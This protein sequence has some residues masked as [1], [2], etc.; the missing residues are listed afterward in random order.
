MNYFLYTFTSNKT[1]IFN[2]ITNSEGI[3]IYPDIVFSHPFSES[4]IEDDELFSVADS[5]I[6]E[7]GSSHIIIASIASTEDRAF[8]ESR[9]NFLHSNTD[10][11]DDSELITRMS[12]YLMLT[13]AMKINFRQLLS[14]YRE[15]GNN[16]SD[17]LIP[18]IDEYD[19]PVSNKN[20]G[21]R[22]YEL[23][24]NQILG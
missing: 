3:S 21:K 18:F 10:S 4:D 9:M 8:L 1:V 15:I 23:I 7:Y 16:P 6:K 2:K 22:I 14:Y 20:E 13:E 17:L 19:L 11:Y 12:G 24:R 5:A